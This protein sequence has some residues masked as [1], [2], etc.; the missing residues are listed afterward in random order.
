MPLSQSFYIGNRKKM[1]ASLPNDSMAIIYSGREIQQSLDANYPFYTDNNFYY[2]TGIE[3]PEVTLI[4]IKDQNGEVSEQL[5]IDEPDPF[6]EK[7][8]G[9]K[10]LPETAQQISGIESIRYT[11]ELEA[12]ILKMKASS[13]HTLC[14]DFTMP[15][16]QSFATSDPEIKA[17]FE[18]MEI[19]DLQPVLT[20]QRLIKQDEEIETLRQAIE[21][22]H[23]GITAIMNGVRPGMKEYQVQAL[24]EYTIND[25]GAQGVSFQSIVASGK[26]A[27]ILHYIKNRNTVEDQTMILLDLGARLNGYCGDISRTIPANGRYTD[28]Q[29]MVYSMVL[30]TQKELIEMYRPGVKMVDIQARTKELF[31]EKCIENHVAPKDHQIDEYYYHNIGHSLGLDTHDTKDKREYLLEPGMVLTCEPGL[32]I[33]SMGIG[34]RIE[35]DILVTENGP[36]NLSPQIP[37]EIADIEKI[38]NP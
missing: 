20:K 37:K 11:R 18:S 30:E 6:K 17:Y 8:V 3:D 1:G 14:F 12:F 4:M 34:V 38:M 31:L 29:A 32:Y 22:T 16:H 36:V 33:A 9:A 27:T 19:F 13:I 23:R 21:I 25:L 24:F 15:P 28:E 35:D 26:N 2:L 7:W 5:F 10:I